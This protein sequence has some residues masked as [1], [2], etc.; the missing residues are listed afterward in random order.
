MK[1]KILAILIGA[2]LLVSMVPVGSMAAKTVAL[3]PKEGNGD[4]FLKFERTVTGT[5]NPTLLSLS[6]VPEAGVTY[7]FSYDIFAAPGFSGYFGVGYYKGLTYDSS[8]IAGTISSTSAA[9]DGW[10]T[11]EKEFTG[12]EDAAAQTATVFK[13]GFTKTSDVGVV[14]LDNMKLYNTAA[15]DV[16]LLENGSFENEFTTASV[17]VTGVEPSPTV[18]VPA[19]SYTYYKGTRSAVVGGELTRISSDEVIAADT[20]KIQSEDFTNL[21]TEAANTSSGGYVSRASRGSVEVTDDPVVANAG[22]KVLKVNNGN[23]SNPVA[24]ILKM[25]GNDTTGAYPNYSDGNTFKVSFRAYIP[26]QDYVSGEETKN[27]ATDGFKFG[28]YYKDAGLRY[29]TSSVEFAGADAGKWLNMEAYVSAFQNSA[30]A[31]SQDVHLRFYINLAGIFYVDDILVEVIDSDAYVSAMN[32]EKSGGHARNAADGGSWAYCVQGTYP[33]SFAKT[34][35][36]RPVIAYTPGNTTAKG[37]AF[38]A[39]YKNEGDTQTLVDI[40]V[41]PVA[42]VARTAYTGVLASEEIGIASDSLAINL[43]GLDLTSGSYSVEYFA[44]DMAGFAPIAAKTFTIAD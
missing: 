10:E 2:L 29:A 33:T 11:K 6:F 4:Y 44:W 8:Y 12:T 21:T 26:A 22:N 17:L 32:V 27:T 37:L 31:P 35:A 34:D 40:K 41:A 23:T 13:I 24:S 1:K 18:S 9:T 25:Q 42:R 36:I 20:I 43:A 38:A 5:N 30:A 3:T 15:P 28:V 7:K 16:N 14:Y 19:A 39:V